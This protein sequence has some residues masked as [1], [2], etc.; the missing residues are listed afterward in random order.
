MGT[1]MFRGEVFMGVAC[2]TLRLSIR[3]GINIWHIQWGKMRSAPTEWANL[4]GSITFSTSMMPHWC[5]IE[6]YFSS[7]MS[8]LRVY[9]IVVLGTPNYSRSSEYINWAIILLSQDTRC[10]HSVYNWILGDVIHILYLTYID[11][12]CWF[13]DYTRWVP[14]F[15]ECILKQLPLQ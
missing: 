3:K 10:Y 6:V 15:S 7:R 11:I 4:Y 8:T 12:C 14:C 5:F 9:H 2:V 13:W 1:Y